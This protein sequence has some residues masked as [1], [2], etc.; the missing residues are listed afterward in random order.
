[1]CNREEGDYVMNVPSDFQEFIFL[2]ECYE[3]QIT[4][5]VVYKVFLEKV[6]SDYT[7]SQYP[8]SL[9][10]SQFHDYIINK[11]GI[12]IPPTFIDSLIK[13]MDD[14]NVDF[15][16]SKGIVV[17]LQC[18]ANIKNKYL[19]TQQKNNNDTI[20]I[21]NYFLQFSRRIFHC[22]IQSSKYFFFR[23]VAGVSPARK[24]SEQRSASEGK[25]FPFYKEVL[26][27]KSK[28]LKVRI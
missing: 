17:F 27:C 25:A 5:D 28:K 26:K 10:I 21:F 20:L 16:I 13:N 11:Y 22:F 15:R 2:S 14:Y 9:R 7:F 8:C 19:R 4:E 23:G 6:I 3:Q 18:P 1:M 12:E 24:G